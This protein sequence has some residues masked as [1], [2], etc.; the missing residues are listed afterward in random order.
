[1]CT[2]SLCY[3]DAFRVFPAYSCGLQGNPAKFL[4]TRQSWFSWLA[5]RKLSSDKVVHDVVKSANDTNIAGELKIVIQQP[6]IVLYRLL[7]CTLFFI[8]VIIYCLFI[9]GEYMLK[10]PQHLYFFLLHRRALF[11]CNFCLGNFIEAS[12]IAF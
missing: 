11:Q 3:T 4:D 5:L 6:F 7:F 12:I 2:I 1:M 10:R 8:V 9:W